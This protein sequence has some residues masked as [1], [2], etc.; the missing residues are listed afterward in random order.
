MEP[1]FIL[2]E[3]LLVHM[4]LKLTKSIGMHKIYKS[5]QQGLDQM[6]AG[7]QKHRQNTPKSA[8]LFYFKNGLFSKVSQES[9]RVC[10]VYYCITLKAE[11][12][13]STF[14]ICYLFE[15]NR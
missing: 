2:Y 12:N 6:Y 8:L 7:H 4:C 3:V 15:V 11:V 9:C 14:N 10:V 13:N 1:Y 5:F